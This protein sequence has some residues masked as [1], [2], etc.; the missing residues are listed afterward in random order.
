MIDPLT[1]SIE[2]GRILFRKVDVTHERDD[3]EDRALG[4]ALEEGHA[5]GEKRRVAV[6]T[7]DHEPANQRPFR[8]RE[9]IEGYEIHAGRTNQ[10]KQ[11]RVNAPLRIVDR[12]G[13]AANDLDGAVSDDGL[14]VGTYLHGLFANEPVRRSFHAWLA[15][16]QLNGP[17][18]APRPTDA[19]TPEIDPHDRWADVLERA[20]DLSLLF[21]RCGLSLPK[22]NLTET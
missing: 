11:A 9:E 20:L 22:T 18:N 8:G 14:V 4:A 5:V 16:R 10:D 19:E 3:A 6:K 21:E 12:S 13:V 2:R 7:V 17:V 1:R 15:S